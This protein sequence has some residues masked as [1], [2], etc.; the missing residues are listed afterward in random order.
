MQKGISSVISI[1]LI[2]LISISMTG[3]AFLFMSRLGN[4]A[5]N[6]SISH[7]ES[8]GKSAQTML[9]VDGIGGDSVYIRNVGSVPIANDTLDFY[10]DN[11]R[12]SVSIQQNISHGEIGDIS[13][14]DTWKF[15]PGKHSLKIT[16]NGPETLQQVEMVPHESSAAYMSLDAISGNAIAEHSGSAYGYLYGIM[17]G[18]IYSSKYSD[19]KSGY[20]MAFDGDNDY[21]VMGTSPLLAPENYLTAMAWVRMDSLSGQQYFISRGRDSWGSGYS[22]YLSSGRFYGEINLDD[23]LNGT[24]IDISS[25]TVPSAGIWYHVALTYSS[26]SGAYLYVNGVPESSSPKTGP[27]VYRSGQGDNF[28]LGVMSYN[29]PNYFDFNGILDGVRI[30]NR[31]LSPEEI[32]AIY[33]SSD[34]TE[35]RKG[36]AGEWNFDEGYGDIAIDSHMAIPG[37][38]GNAIQFTGSESVV[39]EHNGTISPETTVSLWFMISDWQNRAV[40]GRQ[41]YDSITYTQERGWKLYRNA[42]MPQGSLAWVFFYNRTDGTTSSIAPVYTGLSVDTWY[43]AMI[44]VNPDGSFSSYIN[45]ALNSSGSSISGF[46]SWGGTGYQTDARLCLGLPGEE[47][48]NNLKGAVDEVAVYSKALAPGQLLSLRQ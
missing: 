23:A 5:S 8:L 10:I 42:T 7:S 33:S 37:K 46:S 24:E 40:I 1:L 30:Y 32:S 28:V 47:L 9:K 20:G 45:G 38:L 48:G 18:T 29:Y 11:S 35:L 31:V 21:I 13:I 39:T 3:F 6:A 14:L 26:F 15:S 22:L 12:V 17:N 16:G 25:S 34:T 27:I 43:H 41:S 36:L 2:L 19:G 4:Q 44:S